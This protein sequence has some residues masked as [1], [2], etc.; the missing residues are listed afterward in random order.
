MWLRNSKN[1][2]YLPRFAAAQGFNSRTFETFQAV[3]KKLSEKSRTPLQRSLTGHRNDTFRL[4]LA[5]VY[6]PNL[7]SKRC[8]YPFSD[9]FKMFILGNSKQA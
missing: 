9:S 1:R 8:S 2:T 7:R 3:S 4:I 6:R 5:F